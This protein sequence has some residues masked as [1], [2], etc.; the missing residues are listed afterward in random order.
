MI[1]NKANKLS[2]AIRRVF[3]SSDRRFLWPAFQMYVLPG[4][5]YCS[6]F[7]NTNMMSDI[8]SIEA[9][10]R[11][12]S[13]KIGNIRHLPYNSRLQELG[14]LSLE[15]R[16]RYA[17]MVFAYHC[18]HGQLDITAP[19]IGLFILS[20]NTRSGGIR[21]QQQKASPKKCQAHF[22]VRVPSQWNKLPCMSHN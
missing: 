14:V 11:R 17:D 15:N 3:H 2:G 22:S 6:Q 1:V 4:L 19:Q 10:P 5:M 13:K 18:L 7:W 16:R 12:F 20:S 9:V 8:K 21:L